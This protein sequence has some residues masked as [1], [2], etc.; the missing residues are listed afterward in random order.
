MQVLV[1]L[2]RHLLKDIQRK[3]Y[4][5]NKENNKDV[6][7]K[8]PVENKL[9]EAFRIDK[10]SHLVTDSQKH[11]IAKLVHAGALLENKTLILAELR[12]LPATEYG[13]LKLLD[14][15][16]D[17]KDLNQGSFDKFLEFQLNWSQSVKKVWQTKQRVFEDKTERKQ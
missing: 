16:F 10:D 14:L 17:L 6:H 15:L 4:K 13:V 3:D 7:D 1:A 2:C 9:L 12:E 5:K 8:P 11:F